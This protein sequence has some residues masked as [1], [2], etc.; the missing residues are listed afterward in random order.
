VRGDVSS[1]RRRGLTR[2]SGAPLPAGPGSRHSGTGS[3]SG[4]LS[5]KRLR[6][7][8][9][10]WSSESPSSGPNQCSRCRA[11]VRA[12]GSSRRPCF[13]RSCAP[14]VGPPSEASALEDDDVA[15]VI[16]DRLLR[17]LHRDIEGGQLH[18][19]PRGGPQTGRCSGDDPWGVEALPP[20]L[21]QRGPASLTAR[22]SSA[23][24]IELRPA[25][26][27]FLARS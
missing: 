5:S 19:D 21:D 24:F 12:D 20:F 25:T 2:A 27:S 15:V 3:R 9:G 6:R 18:R 26:S 23:L 7:Q 16:D 17:H 1:R 13:G 8:S 22:R 11:Q 10:P 4:R 14:I